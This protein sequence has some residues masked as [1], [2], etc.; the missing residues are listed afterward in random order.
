MKTNKILVNISN[1]DDISKY[2]KLNIFNFLFPLKGYTI[3]YNDFSFNEIKN[4]KGNI[5][6]FMNRILTDNDI[7]EFLELDIPKN[8]KGFIVE[9][10]GLIDILKNK[11]YEVILFQNHLNNNYETVNYWLKYTDS[12]VISTDITGDEIKK[13]VDSSNKPLVLPTLMY[14]M[15]MYSRRT[16]VSNYYRHLGMD[17][18]KELNVSEKISKLN[19]LIKEN[20][21][22]TAI[23][24]N[25]ILD[26][27][28]FSNELDDNKVKFY[29]FNLDTETALKA[30]N[31]EIIDNTTQGFLNKKTIY[32]VGDI[33]D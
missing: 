28:D 12:L 27:R 15:I 7:D 8:I 33:S 3:G 10:I 1:L 31:N 21:Y 2:E 19:F 29:L 16:L 30:L 4:I 24:N 20:K 5:Y 23:F 6:V 26:Y 11:G 9:D 17:G 22:G 18:D 14:P 25:Q 13:I 32:K